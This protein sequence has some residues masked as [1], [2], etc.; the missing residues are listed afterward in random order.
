VRKAR[1]AAAVEAASPTVIS[2]AGRRTAMH[3]PSRSE[4][5]GDAERRYQS[6]GLAGRRRR[7]AAPADEIGRQHPGERQEQQREAEERHGERQGGA[8]GARR[9]LPIGVHRRRPQPQRG[10]QG[11]H[12]QRSV[13]GEDRAPAGV[14]EARRRDPGQRDADRHEG[15]P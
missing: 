2:R 10:E 15:A 6:D 1:I 7:H 5:A 14:R 3:Q 11:S 8:Q 13:D 12:E 9:H 4:A